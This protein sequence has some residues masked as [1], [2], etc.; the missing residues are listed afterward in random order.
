MPPKDEIARR[1]QAIRERIS[2]RGLD[3]LL[4]YSQPGSMLFG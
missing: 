3:L 2:S 4:I 1:L